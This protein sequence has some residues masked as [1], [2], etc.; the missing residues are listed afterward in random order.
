[1][2]PVVLNE[3]KVLVLFTGW[4]KRGVAAGSGVV[5]RLPKVIDLMKRLFD[6]TL[7]VWLLT[8]FSI[9]MAIIAALIRLSSKGPA[10]YWSDLIGKDNTVFKMPKFRTMRQGT[11]AIATHLLNNPDRLPISVK[12]Q[13]DEYYLHH[14]SFGFDLRILAL[15]FIR[16]ARRSGVTH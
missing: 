10:M 2:R 7:A 6:I 15:T 11:P 14:R 16:V 4:G 3:T 12:V 1:M 13:F 8:V 9:P 5:L